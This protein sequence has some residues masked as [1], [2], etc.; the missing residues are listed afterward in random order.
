MNWLLPSMVAG[1]CGPFIL[2]FVFI[3]LCIIYKE[4]HLKMWA[5]SWFIYCI[6]LPITLIFI[7]NNQEN[8]FILLDSIASLSSGL[9]LMLGTLSFIGNKNVSRIWLYFFC[10]GIIW[11]VVW[12][13]LKLPF[14]WIAFPVFYFL[15]ILHIFVGIK[16]LRA[17][18]Y[19]GLGRQI[20]GWSFIIWG[21]HKS[22]YVVIR[23]LDFIKPWAYLFSAI[24]ALMLTAGIL[25]L[26]IQRVLDNLIKSEKKYRTLILN[27]PDTVWT[28][29]VDGKIV[30]VS[31]PVK[32]IYNY[33]HDEISK[34]Q[35]MS[36]F[37][38]VHP[39]DIYHV[40]QTWKKLFSLNI[41]YDIEYR[42]INKDNNIVWIRDRAIRTYNKNGYVFAD[43]ILTDISEKRRDEERLRQYE[44]IVSSSQD[45][46]ALV[47]KNCVFQVA[48][49]A[50]HIAWGKNANELLGSCFSDL[51]EQ[52]VFNK[53]VRKKFDR[54]LS[55]ETVHFQS[56]IDFPAHKKRY[57]DIAYYPLVE[58]NQSISGVVINQRDITQI[59]KLEIYLNNESKIKAISSLAGGIAHRFNNALFCIT[60][61]IE[62]LERYQSNSKKLCNNS[63]F[64]DMKLSAEQMT[65]LTNQL[66]AYSRGGK[67]NTEK[68]NLSCFIEDN[69]SINL[70]T[71]DNSIQIILDLQKDIC[72]I[73]ADANQIKMVLYQIINNSIESFENSGSV[74]I[75]TRK[76]IPAATLIQCN[77]EL[78]SGVYANLTVQDDG[79]GMEDEI[80]SRMFDPFFSTKDY[81]RGLGMASVYGIVKNHSGCIVVESRAEK[82][83]KVEI[84]LPAIPN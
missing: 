45:L 20:T 28:S 54:C 3:Y 44:R 31:Q 56:Y 59:K 52:S 83:T 64:N 26:Y 13:I 43:G 69:F 78:E 2:A 73:E 16:V 84:Y 65:N 62:L 34:I 25:I 68:L 74:L 8:A 48:N 66:L 29:D 70:N 33:S 55:G 12:G 15:G 51:T 24:L 39:D 9:L 38:F 42:I 35:K 40:K 36:R 5:A 23:E 75:K 72:Y 41:E 58:D 32:K 79:K 77:P 50:Y 76:V 80:I 46:M 11:S 47:D 27:I 17:R 21:I 67:Y 30:F 81:G 14:F 49:D 22:Q 57:M 18:N 37:D 71:A 19:K 1:L 6:R 53:T 7:L 10:L 63:K 60:G 82:G 4:N 61:N